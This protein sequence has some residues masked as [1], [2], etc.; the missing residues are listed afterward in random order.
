MSSFDESR[1]Q[2]ILE[3]QFFSRRFGMNLPDF[4]AQDQYGYIHVAG[5]RIGL[6]HVVELYNDGYTPEMLHDHFPTLSRALVH[7]LI[8]FYL[9]NQS[10]VDT[11]CLQSRIALDR[12]SAG[13][14][15]GP[16]AEELR[17]RMEAMRPKESA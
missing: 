15:Q 3:V 12:Q 6:R 16:D 1:L 9:E 13:P 8:A 10:E 17:R 14:Q 11:Y 7:K 5:H 2:V 4:L